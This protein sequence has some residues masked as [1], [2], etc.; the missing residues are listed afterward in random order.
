MLG[1]VCFFSPKG[2]GYIRPDAD[3]PDI[4]FHKSG[5]LGVTQRKI[6]TDLTVEFDVAE[7]NGKPIAVNVRIPDYV[8]AKPLIAFAAPCAEELFKAMAV[9]S[10]SAVQQ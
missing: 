3:S 10:D 9:L 5:L 1:K 2:F 8:T 6:V 4:Y 7:R